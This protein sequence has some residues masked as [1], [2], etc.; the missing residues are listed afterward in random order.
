MPPEEG[1]LEDGAP[2]ALLWSGMELELPLMLDPEPLF[3]LEPLE[4]RLESRDSVCWSSCAVCRSPDF[5]WNCEIADL[6]CGP[7]MPSTEPL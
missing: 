7:T 3:S 4:P 6:V 5:F 1:A 2:V